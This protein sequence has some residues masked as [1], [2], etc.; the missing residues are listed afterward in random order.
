MNDHHSDGARGWNPR[1]RYQQKVNRFSNDSHSMNSHCRLVAQLR[2]R[3]AWCGA[4][5]DLK[6][7]DEVKQQ[8]RP[9]MPQKLVVHAFPFNIFPFFLSKTLTSSY[10]FNPSLS[11]KISLNPYYPHTLTLSKHIISHF[12]RWTLVV[13]NQISTLVNL[14]LLAFWARLIAWLVASLDFVIFYIH[15]E[16]L[17]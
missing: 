8:L 2:S 15:C 5:L 6:K 11:T 10:F 9:E 17:C 13:E 7:R 16:V 12:W 1:R 14:G 3:T 4:G